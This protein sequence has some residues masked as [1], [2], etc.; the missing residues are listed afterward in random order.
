EHRFDEFR[1]LL[2]RMANLSAVSIQN[3]Q[4]FNQAI[5]LQGFNESVLESIQ[6]G[7]VVLDKSG[8]ILSVNDFMRQR[9]GWNEVEALHQDLFVY[10]PDLS[11]ILKSDVRDVLDTGQPRERI[12][13]NTVQ[14]DGK[15]LVRN[16]YTYP[17]QTAD[18]VR[19][20]VLLVEDVTE[21]ARLERDLEGRANQL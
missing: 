5:N 10:R 17:L 19:G 21:R 14:P 1:P 12:G 9:Y 15:Q 13:Q 2:K 11:S 6:Q 4:L 8:R 16:F 18:S 7:I 3:A 20:A